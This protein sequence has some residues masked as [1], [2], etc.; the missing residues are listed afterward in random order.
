MAYQID[1][2]IFLSEPNYNICIN[3]NQLEFEKKLIIPCFNP[4]VFNII[5]THKITSLIG[6]FV[7][8]TIIQKEKKFNYKVKISLMK[9]YGDPI[10]E[11]ITNFYPTSKPM[12]LKY[13]P[14]QC[15]KCKFE[16]EYTSITGVRLLVDDLKTY[17]DGQPNVILCGSDANISVSKFLLELRSSVL[18]AMFNHDMKENKTLTIDLKEFKSNTLQA[19]CNFLLHDKVELNNEIAFQLYLLGDKYDIQGLKNSSIEYILANLK[20]F[21]KDEVFS[22]LIKTNEQLFKQLLFEKYLVIN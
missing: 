14:M 9:D 13:S 1:G 7:T 6:N 15:I 16:F 22:I 18:K 4:Y 5:A 20:D 3:Q 8:F 21:D 19:F 2:V 11:T 10:I 17:L 12:Y